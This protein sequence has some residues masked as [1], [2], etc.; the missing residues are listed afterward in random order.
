MSDI[1]YPLSMVL[2]AELIESEFV[3][4]NW[5]TFAILPISDTAVSPFKVTRTDRDF[6]TI[7][8]QALWQFANLLLY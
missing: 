7:N 1:P 6:V 3:I 4:S 5:M 8:Q 2:T